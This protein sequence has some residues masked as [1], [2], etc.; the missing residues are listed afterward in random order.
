MSNFLNTNID[1]FGLDISDSYLRIAKIKKNKKGLYLSSFAEKEIDLKDK[2]E[3]SKFLGL[4]IK[5]LI[6]K[7]KGDKINTR[8]VALS[9]PEEKSFLQ[10]I[11]MPKMKEEELKKALAYEAENYIP[12]PMN[13]V[14]F[15]FQIIRS[16]EEKNLLEILVIAFPKKIIDNHIYFIEKAGFIPTILEI[17]PISIARSVIKNNQEV[18]PTLLIDI[19]K[20]R[21][22][23]IIF[24]KKSIRFTSSVFFPLEEL[25]KKDNNDFLS[26]VID[27][28]IKTTKKCLSF[29]DSR[30]FGS[31]FDS[32]IEN[33]DNIIISGE[34]KNL[35][36]FAQKLLEEIDI[37]I[38][39][40]D[41]FA[42][43]YKGEFNIS[44]NEALNYRI[45]FGLAL[46]SFI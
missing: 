43:F 19:G 24:S 17:E 31:S 34:G 7:T 38:K 3:D 29:Y 35:N 45:A 11:E 39:I 15:D 22:S 36:D 27:E 44:K 25:N 10:V 4:A 41:P 5:D 32:D 6:K 33:I 46:R 23:F 20:T 21:A 30:H 16:F 42:N 9:L 2:I 40:G 37:K 14:Y 8:H 12:L 26:P 13:D 28:V 1:F 18:S